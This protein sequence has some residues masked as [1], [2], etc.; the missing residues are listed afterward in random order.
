M[1]QDFIQTGN[2]IDR[3][4]RLFLNR[5]LILKEKVPTDEKKPLPLVL[6]YIGTISLQTGTKLQ[7]P[8]KGVLNCCRL[9]VIFESQNKLCNNFRVKDPVPQVLTLGMVCKFQCRLCNEFYYVEC[10]RQLTVRSGEHIS[11]SPLTNKRV[12]PRKDSA[13]CYYF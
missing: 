6:P 5:I 13:A 8:I 1:W 3:W 7:K 11:I 10:I 4:F 2:L 12:Q 9:Q